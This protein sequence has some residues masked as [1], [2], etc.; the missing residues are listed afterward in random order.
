MEHISEILPR[1]LNGAALVP[2]QAA[3][4]PAPRP[5]TLVELVPYLEAIESK[6]NPDVVVEARALRMNSEGLLE[7]P[8]LGAY[9]PTDWSL[10]QIARFA[11][12]EAQS[13]VRE[14]GRSDAR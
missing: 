8:T 4:M 2:F 14:R 12:G 9:A 1:A 6:D 13:V 11:G 5:T 10:S 7:I 3:A